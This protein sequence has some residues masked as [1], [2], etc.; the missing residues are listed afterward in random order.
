ME[1]EPGKGCA[2]VCPVSYGNLQGTVA[3]ILDLKGSEILD[4]LFVSVFF[5]SNY[6]SHSR[7]QICERV[8]GVN[9]RS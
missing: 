7:A 5:A 1:R 2:I 9:L 8:E 6:E 3:F 4:S